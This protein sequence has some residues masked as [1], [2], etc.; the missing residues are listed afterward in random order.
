[1]PSR[2]FKF[3]STVALFIMY[4]LINLMFSKDL[5]IV[6]LWAFQLFIRNLKNFN[7]TCRDLI[8]A[9]AS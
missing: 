4:I 8:A 7:N 3:V 1:M 5:N 6:N 9:L 2:K